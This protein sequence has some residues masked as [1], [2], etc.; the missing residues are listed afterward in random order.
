ML[1]NKILHVI[2]KKLVK[3]WLE[4]VAEIAK[5]KDD[6]NFSYPSGSLLSVTLAL[7]TNLAGIVI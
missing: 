7:P 4:M 2:K 3:K 6:F 5:K 1:Q